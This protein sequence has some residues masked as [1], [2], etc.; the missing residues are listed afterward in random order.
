MNLRYADFIVNE[1][2]P[3]GD[4]VHLTT[5]NPSKSKVSPKK[6][7]DDDPPATDDLNSTNEKHYPAPEN[8]HTEKDNDLQPADSS[9]KDKAHDGPKSTVDATY[10]GS[11]PF[12]AP[13]GEHTEKE[14]DIKPT[15]GGAEYEVQNGLKSTNEVIPASSELH[16]APDE[17]RTE[18]EDDSKP[19]NGGQEDKVPDVLDVDRKETSDNLHPETAALAKWEESRDKSEV[20]VS[21][22]YR[23]RSYINNACIRCP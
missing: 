14:K 18:K 13:D 6:G 12:E 21:R 3:S 1:I 23:P 16:R 8:D 17:E 4:V 19:T 10:V 9:G 20:Q 2:L 22:S 11:E 5:L 15:D 7:P